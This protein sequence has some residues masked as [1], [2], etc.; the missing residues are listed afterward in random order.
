MWNFSGNMIVTFRGISSQTVS[1]KPF[2]VINTIDEVID[3]AVTAPK[4]TNSTSLSG[5]RYSSIPWV[6]FICIAVLQF[7]SAGLKPPLVDVHW[8]SPI[9]L[10]EA[11]RFAETD[12]LNNYAQHAEEITAASKNS[13]SFWRPYWHFIRLGHIAILGT[14]IQ[15]FGPIETGIKAAHWL[16]NGIMA[17]ALFLSTLWVVEI[18]KFLGISYSKSSINWAIVI[19]A[20]L[21]MQ[22]GSYSYLGR[23]LVSEVPAL[24]LLSAA[25]LSL[26]KGLNHHS[27]SLIAFSGILACM[28]YIVR[29]ESI[30][31]LASFY[32]ILFFFDCKTKWKS[33]WYAGYAIAA[34]TALTGF[35]FYS[36]AFYPLTDPRLFLTFTK[37]VDIDH[38]EVNPIINIMA[39]GGF[40]WFGTVI[41]LLG[42]KWTATKW[43]VLAWVAILLL[44]TIPHLISGASV[45]TRM[46]V[47]LILLPL[48]FSS[49]LGWAYILKLYS[50]NI[51]IFFIVI[52]IIIVTSS[53]ELVSR[54]LEQIPFL[55]RAKYIRQYIKPILGPPKYE[56]VTYPIKDLQHIS[57]AIYQK[58]DAKSIF[59]FSGKL[60]SIY[61]LRFFGP[62]FVYPDDFTMGHDLPILNPCQF[63]N[64][65]KNKFESVF[66]CSGASDT[67]IEQLQNQGLNV[68]YLD[69]V[70]NFPAIQPT[71][72]QPASRQSLIP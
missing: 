57:K 62:A 16:Y 6:L 25:C 32:I 72:P 65:V 13:G 56:Q 39:A 47:P 4:K 40:L 71:N 63:H 61:L 68:N 20:I 59:V 29:M 48:L 7:I 30:W 22:S 53:Y 64:S 52:T 28:L 34:L 24:F 69:Q 18:L 51:R 66:Y 31:W 23:S 9:Y 70:K 10:H 67:Q 33:F 38:D 27:I 17:G 37:I 58:T 26:V 35:I 3:Q 45:Q 55:W 60:G 15:N 1:S 44:P 11:K 36:W 50:I 46:F 42:D 14:L 12:Y 49:T 21:Y 2:L 19:S 5:G 8:D 43:L 54:K 41:W